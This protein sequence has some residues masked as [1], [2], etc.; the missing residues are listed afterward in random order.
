MRNSIRLF[1]NSVIS[2]SRYRSVTRPHYKNNAA[3]ATMM[4]PNHL[5]VASPVL[6]GASFSTKPPTTPSPPAVAAPT[7]P[8]VP[9]KTA[10]TAVPSVEN[11]INPITERREMMSKMDGHVVYYNE[12][13]EKQYLPGP[14]LPDN[15]KEMTAMDSSDVAFHNIKEDGTKR[16]VYIRQME[17][18]SKQAPLN[19]ES[20]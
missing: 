4:I 17:K 14:K 10:T 5:C 13:A 7:K 2:G 6:A 1:N 18:N 20:C 11:E 12:L 19:P 3:V 9:T 8:P 16:M 15:V